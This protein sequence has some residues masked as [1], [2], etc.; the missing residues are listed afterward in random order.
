MFEDCELW[1]FDEAFLRSF[2]CAIPEYKFP[3]LVR[4]FYSNLNY[5]GGILTSELNEQHIRL[6]LK[7]FTK[8]YNL[9]CI[10]LEYKADEDARIVYS[11]TPI[12]ISLLANPIFGVPCN[13]RL[14]GIGRGV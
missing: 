4:M 10:N 8:I 3:N 2:I 7:E 12:V 1:L 13:T 11:Y 5:I 9:P 6:S 14:D